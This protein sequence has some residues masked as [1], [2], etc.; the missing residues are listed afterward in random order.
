MAQNKWQE[1]CQAVG[2][3]R[4][5]GIAEHSATTGLAVAESSDEGEAG[6]SWSRKIGTTSAAA[7]QSV[8]EVR[9]PGIAR[10][11]WSRQKLFGGDEPSWSRAHGA[12]SAD[13]T[14]AVKT[15]GKDRALGEAGRV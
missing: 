1:Q 7:A 4:L 6:S 13:V 11:T 12:A 8:G 14:A 3:A 15:A 2:E 5:P 10:N 9:P